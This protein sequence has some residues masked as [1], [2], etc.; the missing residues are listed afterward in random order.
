[1]AHPTGRLSC[2]TYHLRTVA[3]HLCFSDRPVSSSSPQRTPCTPRILSFTMLESM[4]PPRALVLPWSSAVKGRERAQDGRFSYCW[5]QGCPGFA[6]PPQGT[7]GP[8]VSVVPAGGAKST[9]A[10]RLSPLRVW[11]LPLAKAEGPAIH[12][13]PPAS[14]LHAHRPHLPEDKGLHCLQPLRLAP[15]PPPMASLWLPEEG[16]TRFLL[17]VL[18]PL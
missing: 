7:L 9:P 18:T 5:K 13:P 10:G 12:C 15:Q 6:L 17:L 8:W 3:S 11:I 14:W 16:R 4:L 1:M 2:S